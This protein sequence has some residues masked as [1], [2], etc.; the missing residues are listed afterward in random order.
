MLCCDWSSKFNM[1]ATGGADRLLI[2]WNPFSCKP[3]AQLTGHS[4][5]IQRV[6][7]NEENHQIISLSSDKV[8][9]VGLMLCGMRF[10]A[11]HFSL[12]VMPLNSASSG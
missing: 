3:L 10:R 6:T 2:L 11:S 1:L 12:C 5:P 9:K 8:I 4:A 7:V